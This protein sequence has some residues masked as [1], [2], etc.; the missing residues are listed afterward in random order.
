MITA[1]GPAAVAFVT[2]AVL[3]PILIRW[4]RSRNLLDVPNDRSSHAV[5]TP[6]VGG[7]AIVAAVVVAVALT[8]HARELT[9]L[10]LGGLAIALLSLVDDFRS[11]SPLV[12]LVAHFTIAA[13]VVG[14]AGP[15]DLSA[16][17]IGPA[18][19]VPLTLLWIVG[20]VNAYNFM[21]GIDGIAGIQAVLAAAAWMIIAGPAG[22]PATAVL[23]GAV[24]GAT[25]AFLLFNWSPARVFMGDAGSAFLGYALAVFPLIPGP[26]PTV[27][28]FAALLVVWPFMFDSVVTFLR[29]LFRGENVMLAHRSHLYQRLC[30]TEWS[31]RAVSSLYGVLALAGGV[32]AVSTVTAPAAMTAAG[33]AGICVMAAGLWVFVARRERIRN[34]AAGSAA[35]STR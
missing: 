34:S 31:H 29:R 30:A 4:A 1:A 28:P 33:I 9:V 8:P 5:P 35:G 12:R 11:L 15:L 3:V 16:V 10:A 23:A 25:L 6:R 2:V 20:L 13:F 32:V 14:A 27:L 26:H 7:V 19:A 22:S 17:R 21:D 24:A 18:L